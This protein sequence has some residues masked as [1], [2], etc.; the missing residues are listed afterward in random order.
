MEEPLPFLKGPWFTT[1]VPTKER[2]RLQLESRVEILG[3]G[4]KGMH[5][6]ENSFFTNF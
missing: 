2:R 3:K 5:S 4:I 6:S 1:M